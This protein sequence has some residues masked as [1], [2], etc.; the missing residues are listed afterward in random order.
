LCHS[1]AFFPG[2]AW[3]AQS[4]VAV[5][6][7]SSGGAPSF[8]LVLDALE[9]TA[10]GRLA[11]IELCRHHAS[12]FLQTSGGDNLQG[13]STTK[14]PLLD[15]G[16][17]AAA[18]ELCVRS[19]EYLLTV[20]LAHAAMDSGLRFETADVAAFGRKAAIAAALDASPFAAAV[21]KQLLR[22]G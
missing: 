3:D 17:A 14:A 4:S 16:A 5:A 7:A 8:N 2:H 9:Q 1:A 12:V 18:Y 22:L 10:A 13:S 19:F 11:T 21:T 6:A 20:W 15:A